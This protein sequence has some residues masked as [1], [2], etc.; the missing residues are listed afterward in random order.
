MLGALV[1]R[2]VVRYCIQVSEGPHLND[3]TFCTFLGSYF[4]TCNTFLFV[5]L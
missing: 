4:L 5:Y 3:M 1:T 2:D